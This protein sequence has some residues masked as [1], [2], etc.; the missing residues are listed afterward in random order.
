[1]GA[2]QKSHISQPLVPQKYV[3]AGR[4]VSELVE[5]EAGKLKDGYVHGAAGHGKNSAPNSHRKTFLFSCRRR[6]KWSLNSEIIRPR[7]SLSFCWHSR[8][9]SHMPV[10]L[11]ACPIKVG[12]SGNTTNFRCG[13]MAH[14]STLVHVENALA[15]FT[16]EATFLPLFGGYF[17][18]AITCESVCIHTNWMHCWN[19]L[20]LQFFG[21]LVGNE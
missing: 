14:K 15:L 6:K 16:S 9:F 11:S 7:S 17:N 21:F 13:V 19:F 18:I 8:S 1:M 10:W 20:S 12:Y 2:R 5:Q 4:H 3:Q